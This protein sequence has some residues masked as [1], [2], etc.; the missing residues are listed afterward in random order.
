QPSRI[1]RP[2]PPKHPRPRR[3][4][5]R[6]DLAIDG[7]P[8]MP[9][10]VPDRSH[11]HQ[12]AAHLHRFAGVRPHRF[13]SSPDHC[14]HCLFAELSAARTM[15]ATG[16][17]TVSATDAVH[18]HTNRLIHE[19]SPYLLQHAHNPVDWYAWGPEAFDAAKEQNKPIFLSVGDRKSV[20]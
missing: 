7:N 18:S 12:P 10:R 15:H 17:E 4:R 20:V 3:L 6:I 16:A 9:P 2:E 8:Q 13:G 5:P 14:R 11:P 19:S 1:R